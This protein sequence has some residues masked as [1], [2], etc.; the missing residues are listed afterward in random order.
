MHRR[1]VSRVPREWRNPDDWPKPPDSA[2]PEEHRSTYMARCGALTDYLEGK[3]LAAIRE[4][5]NIDSS[6][7]YK[8]LD[9]C[10][11]P[12]PAGGIRGFSAVIPYARTSGYVRKTDV[13]PD[14][15]AAGRGTAGLFTALLADH[16]PLAAYVEERAKKYATAA[17]EKRRLPIRAEHDAF[18]TRAAEFLKNDQYP[19]TLRSRAR[20]GFRTALHEA[21]AKH[22]GAQAAHLEPSMWLRFRGEHPAY[23]RRI[24]I[25]AHQLDGFISARV[26]GKKGRFRTK[27]LRPWLIAAVEVESTNLVGWHLSIDDEPSAEDVLCCLYDMM[28]NDDGHRV[29]DM[30][31]FSLEDGKGLPSLVVDGCA[32]RY[33][34]VVELDNALAHH[35]HIVREAITTKLFASIQHGCSHEP[36]RRV[37]IEQSFNTLTHRNIQHSLMGI[38]PDATDRERAIAEENAGGMTVEAMEAYLRMVLGRHNDAPTDAHYGKVRLQCLR[39]EPTYELRRA[40]TSVRASWRSLVEREIVTPIR[41]SDGHPPHVNLLN[42]TYSNDLLRAAYDL[43]GRDVIVVVNLNQPRIARAYIKGGLSFGVLTV[44]GPWRD[45]EHD[46]R[47]RRFLSRAKG[48]GRFHWV[49][50]KSPEECVNDFLKRVGGERASQKRR[51]GG[52]SK[53]QSARADQAQGGVSKARPETKLVSKLAEV[54]TLDIASILG[55]KLEG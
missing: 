36:R 5:Y 50:G 53:L 24:Q 48:D 39:E 12:A 11:K 29:V 55:R 52:N 37:Q 2:V 51:A 47:L 33:P 30:P 23:Y 38:R 7:L 4:A 19:F 40:D 54:Q 17:W 9:A 27:R 1:V 8:F 6:A 28:R 22:R 49:P 21:I 10:L 35:A 18:C 26:E 14:Q 44:L 46:Y 32:S 41:A 31:E 3:S 20:E 34:D 42:A 45:F 13:N 25:D 16:K 15:L 43:V